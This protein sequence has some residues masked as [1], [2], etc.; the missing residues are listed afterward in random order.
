MNKKCA[1]GSKLHF[2][3][4]VRTGQPMMQPSDMKVLMRFVYILQW[5]V[6]TE[7][8]SGQLMSGLGF[9]SGLLF[10]DCWD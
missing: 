1:H 4:I 8:I 9:D 10:R 6:G 3:N 2:F 5:Q 7:W